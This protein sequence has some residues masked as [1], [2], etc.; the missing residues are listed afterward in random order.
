MVRRSVGR[1]IRRTELLDKR[2]SEEQQASS[3]RLAHLAC[4]RTS[5]RD[6]GLQDDYD[7]SEYSPDLPTPSCSYARS[8]NP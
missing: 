3:Q 2:P 8:H 6:N 1:Q 7:M 5:F 4:T